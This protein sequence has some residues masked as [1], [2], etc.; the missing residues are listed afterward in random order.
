LRPIRPN[1]LMPI[2]TVMI[3]RSLAKIRGVHGGA[4]S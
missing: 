2:F 1:P 3:E 4:P